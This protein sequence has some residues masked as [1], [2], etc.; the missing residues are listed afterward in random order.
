MAVSAADRPVPMLSA[1][2]TEGLCNASVPASE[3]PPDA[4][5]QVIEGQTEVPAHASKES[6]EG[7]ENDLP[8]VPAQESCNEGFEDKP[9]RVPAQEFCDERIQG[10]L[11]SSMPTEP[12]LGFS[13]C[14][15]F[16][17]LLWF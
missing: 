16:R 13:S 1:H 11:S 12:H 6:L 14:P 10:T 7:V 4:S 5:A 8:F 17:V 9:P 15:A 2:G 3:G